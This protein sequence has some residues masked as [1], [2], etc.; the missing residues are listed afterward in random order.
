MWPS[1][2]ILTLLAY[3]NPFINPLLHYTHHS[4]QGTAKAHGAPLG[5]EDLANTK[6]HYNFDPTKFFNIESDVAA[7]YKSVSAEVEAEKTRWDAMMLAYAKEEPALCAEYNRRFNG[8]LPAGLLDLLPIYAAGSS[9]AASRKISEACINSIAD[10]MPELMG[11]SADLTPSNLTSLKCSKDFQKNSPDGRYI[12]FGVREHGMAAICNGMFAHGGLR[13]YC[14]TFLNFAG[15]ALG[16][17]R[18]SA[19]SRF[20]VVYV[21]TH[22][23]IGLGEDGPTHQP[24][25]MI[26]SLRSMPNCNVLRPCDIN[27]TN[28]AYQ[29]ALEQ[30]G[31]P[32]VICLS[33]QGLP[34]LA[35]SEVAKAKMGGYILRDA[36][37]P[38]I[39]LV[40]TGSETGLCYKAADELKTAGI[41]ARVVSMMCMDV[42]DEQSE[43]YKKSV[44][45]EG[46]PTLAVEAAAVGSWNKYSHVQICMRRFGASAKGGD[47]MKRF[48][49]TLGNVVEKS[50]RIV[51]FYKSTACPSLFA[52]PVFDDEV[53][54]G[55]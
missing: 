15:Y 21:M 49:F 12:R 41:N 38:D 23:S 37:S 3:P 8:E 52:R 25:E 4:K 6:K 13:P 43:A 9:D 24:V 22:D 19:L 1:W 35:G 45:G 28:A 33:R 5:D 30:S 32:S 26:E 53:A 34:N 40:G 7:H 50:K 14:A 11:G 46:I 55:H 51:E 18:V 44:L 36:A 20:G 39:V 17:I 27:E 31:T 2:P 10:K 47:L 42:F 48:G 16:S 54:G 29:I